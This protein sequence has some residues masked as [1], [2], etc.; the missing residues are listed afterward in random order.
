MLWIIIIGNATSVTT[1]GMYKRSRHLWRA[2]CDYPK[3]S[4][5]DAPFLSMI[6]N[7][8]YSS[9][10]GSIGQLIKPLL[11]GWE[12]GGLGSKSMKKKRGLS[13]S[14]KQNDAIIIMI[15]T[16][17]LVCH[18][19]DGHLMINKPHHNTPHAFLK[20]RYVSTKTPKNGRLISSQQGKSFAG[21]IPES[22]S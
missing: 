8:D 13:G 11:R 18:H 20:D 7:S 21:A 22:A 6:A 15:A 4:T 16:L 14:K 5:H 3:E 2:E 17:C 9:W 1:V 12:L 19:Y 10:W